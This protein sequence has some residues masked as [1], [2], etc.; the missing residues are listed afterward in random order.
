MEIAN[1]TQHMATIEQIEQGVFNLI[2]ADRKT[3][4]ELLTFNDIPTRN[5]MNE[6]AEAI[7]ELMANA[8]YHNATHAMIGGAPYFMA[9]LE[10]AL[11]KKGIIPLYAFTERQSIEKIID[12]ETVKTSV[13]VHKGFVEADSSNKRF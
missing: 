12:G 8:T 6:R 7:A 2:E 10:K 9:Y 13:F 1:L 3:L 5:E 4:K 11:G